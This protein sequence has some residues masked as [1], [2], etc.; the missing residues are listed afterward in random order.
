LVAERGPLSSQRFTHLEEVNMIIARRKSWSQWTPRRR[1]NLIKGLLF[2]SP[3]LIGL[4]LFTVYPI[5]ASLY[6][7]FTEYDVVRP[8]I[9][10]GFKNYINIAK[11]DV[12]WKSLYNTIFFVI[13]GIPG[14]LSIAFALAVLLN[15]KIRF[16][17]LF[18]AIFYIPVLVPVVASA[19]VWRWLFDVRIGLLNFILGFV[20]IRPIPWIADPAWAKPSLLLVHFW[21]CGGAMIIFLAALQDVP[22]SLYDAAKID[23]ANNWNQ[24][25]YVTLPLCTPAIL[26][27]SIMGV[28]ETFQIFSIVWILTKGGP[29]YATE[30]YVVYLYRN[31]FSYFKMGYASAL[32]WILSLIILGCVFLLYRTSARWVFYG[33][34]QY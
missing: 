20:G 19:F 14:Q 29:N 24:F 23:G 30:F 1:R 11:D 34:E 27:N 9:P 15:Q 5:F 2:I 6:Y 16:R 22:K 28:I 8:P 17:S 3:W 7:S 13:F 26:F 4:L 33:G 21:V 25:W 32:A 18:R 10:V 12:F 31:A